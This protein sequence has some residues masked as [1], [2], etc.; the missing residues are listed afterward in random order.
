MTPPASVLSL[1][2]LTNSRARTRVPKPQGTTGRVGTGK[3]G[4]A[5]SGRESPAVPARLL[6][7]LLFRDPYRPEGRGPCFTVRSRRI[8][9]NLR[10]SSGQ[11]SAGTST[12]TFCKCRAHL[13]KPAGVGTVERIASRVFCLRALIKR[14]LRSRWLPYRRFELISS[15]LC[16]FPLM[17]HLI[18]LE[19]QDAGDSAF[20]CI[21][22]FPL[23]CIA[24]CRRRLQ[25]A[26]FGSWP[27]YAYFGPFRTARRPGQGCDSQ[28]R[29]HF[30]VLGF[31]H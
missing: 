2:S 19:L 17:L 27:R 29:I 4:G 31:E 14:F 21:E 25:A 13:W 10:G 26:S 11:G 5:S 6:A 24:S 7:G 3:A 8:N 23:A 15:S 22:I 28:P 30:L 9:F 12:S 18:G 16:H 1:L 20:N